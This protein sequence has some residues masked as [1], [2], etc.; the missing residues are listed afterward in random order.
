MQQLKVTY[1]PEAKNDLTNIFEII[2]QLSNHHITAENFVLRITKRCES[3][4]NAPYGGRSRDDLEEGLRTVPF[5][6]T[7]IISYKVE[8]DCVRIFN[9]FYGGRDYEA[10]FEN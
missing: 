10:L 1:R 6:K 8:H 2:L 7:V 4:G 5:E 3:I 9:I